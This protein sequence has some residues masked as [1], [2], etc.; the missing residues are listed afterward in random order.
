MAIKL[1]FLFGSDS[2]KSLQEI[3]LA[4]KKTKRRKK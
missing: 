4:K 1:T 2:E 3:L